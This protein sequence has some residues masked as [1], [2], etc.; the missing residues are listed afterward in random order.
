MGP[1]GSVDTI[2]PRATAEP[3]AAQSAL[4]SQEASDAP[5]VEPAEDP[6]ALTRPAVEQ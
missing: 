6:E 4:P 3:S 2:G 5:A 1:E